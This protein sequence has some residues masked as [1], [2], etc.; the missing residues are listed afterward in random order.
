MGG[1]EGSNVGA[2]VGLGSRH[3]GFQGTREL[4]MVPLPDAQDHQASM[5]RSSGPGEWQEHCPKGEVHNH[6]HPGLCADARAAP[7]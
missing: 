6:A 2:G 3:Q 1:T 7:S 4:S 5:L